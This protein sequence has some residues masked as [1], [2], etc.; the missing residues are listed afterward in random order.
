[1][2]ANRYIDLQPNNILMGIDDES[3]F[4][5]YEKEELEHHRAP[6]NGQ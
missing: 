4:S 6:K 5:D 2:I 1:M 3:V